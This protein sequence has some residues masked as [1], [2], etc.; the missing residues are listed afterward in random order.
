M[1]K[2][3]GSTL[4]ATRRD[5]AR[6]AL[7][8]AL[9]EAALAPLQAAPAAKLRPLTP[10]I[11]ITLQIPA[12]PSAQDFQFANQLGVE[13]VS[14]PTDGDAA[15][16]DNFVRRKQAAENHGLK[17]W[18]IG[19]SN[20]HNMPEVTLN[21]P[22]RDRKIEEYKTYLRNLAQAGIYTPPTRIW[23]TAFGAPRRRQRGAARRRELSTW[24]R[25]ARATGSRR[26]TGLRCRMA[27]GTARKRSGRI[28]PTSSSRL[29]PLP[30]NLA[31]GSA[32]IPTIRRSLRSAA[33]HA[34]S[35]ATSTATFAH[36][37][38]PIARTSACACAAA[39]GSNAAS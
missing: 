3:L 23:R 33:F 4:N 18:N 27:A 11:K 12:N 28:T 31:S 25:A 36:W 38:S 7:G 6:L 22:G 1:V 13:Y 29:R 17:V 15:T 24:P 32:F 2:A 34:A 5:F 21:L 14:I 8:T 30:K 9:A 35:S 19:N 39:H 37:R 20:V 26:S 16:L 10:G